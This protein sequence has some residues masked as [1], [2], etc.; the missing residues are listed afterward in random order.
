MPI[1]QE[2]SYQ[3]KIKTIQ[4]IQEIIGPFPRRKKVI[5]CHG[6]FDLVHPGH[7]RH[8]MYAKS[9][10]HILIASL[11]CDAH[12]SKANYRPYVPQ[13][14][15][16]MNIAALEVV[17]YVL[18][19]DHPTPINTILSLQPDYFAKGYEYVKNG[20]PPQTR[21][22]ETA[23]KKYGGELIFTPGDVI[24]SSSKIISDG[25]PKI[26]TDKLAILM[27]SEKISFQMI[28]DTLQSF[29]GKTVHVLGDTIVDSY[30]YCS[31]LSAA[32]KTPT[33]SVKYDNQVNYS[34]GA[35]VVSKHIRKAGA[36]VI[37]STVLG[38]DLLKEWVLRDLAQND[39]Q[40]LPCIDSTR[41]TTQKKVFTANNYRLLKVDK[42]D[43]H[44][45][46]DT[47]Q[48]KLSR[49]LSDSQV[50]AYVFSDFRHGIFHRESIPQF[51]KCLDKR[52]LRVADSQVATRWGNILDFSEF[53]LI[54][55]NEKEARFALA[56]QDSVIRP[57]ALDLYKRANCKTLMLKLG[58]KGVVTYIAPSHSVRSFFTVDSFVDHVV[59]PVGAG[60]ALLAY[61]TLS[62]IVSNSPV[63]A[64][65]LGAMAAAVACEHEGNQPVLPTEVAKKLQSIENRINFIPPHST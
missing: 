7:L 8:L 24:Y 64:T 51:K 16:A 37:F 28:H 41:P 38:D 30:V 33:F 14:L 32:A 59:D 25:P 1:T 19:D 6:V 34:G 65:I 15:R 44:P 54:T 40:C 9:K 42:L 36:H 48:K 46:S 56:D 29:E 52:S 12:I 50:D 17:D 60:D 21:E 13:N 49:Q 23:L 55:P 39:I 2:T 5:M 10:A 26:A 53:D 63:I 57:L 18:I 58:D 31:F 45:M 61:A 35:A 3:R 27:E 4:E 20:L 22:E 47:I 62:M 43:N 11:T